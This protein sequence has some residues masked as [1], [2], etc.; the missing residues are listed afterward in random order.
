MNDRISIQESVDAF[1][2]LSSD[3]LKSLRDINDRIQGFKGKW[4]IYHESKQ[5]ESGALT[6]PWVEQEPLIQ[7]FVQLMYE[8]HLV[9][10]FDWPNWQEGRDW[11]VL[12]DDSKYAK[13][14]V[15]T[16]L[17]LLTAIMRNDRFNEGALVNAFDSGTF[18][19]IIQN[20]ITI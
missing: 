17:K 10:K 1:K 15:E 14:D 8:K 2:R 12:Q 3:E 13:L 6:F 4:G 7:E 9:V 20:L 19:K 5:T 18:P 11:Y 16:S